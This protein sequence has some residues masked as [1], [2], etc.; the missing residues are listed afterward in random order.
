[1]L[2]LQTTRRK[3]Y[4]ILLKN[5]ITDKRNEYS[6]L[7]NQEDGYT[8]NEYFQ[9]SQTLGRIFRRWR[10]YPDA[11][12]ES[13][14]NRRTIGYVVRAVDGEFKDIR[15]EIQ[16]Y[17]VKC[18]GHQNSTT[19]HMHVMAGKIVIYYVTDY[20]LG[21][22]APEFATVEAKKRLRFDGSTDIQVLK[23]LTIPHVS[24]L[25]NSE[26]IKVGCP[27]VL[28]HKSDFIKAFDTIVPGKRMFSDDGQPMREFLAFC[29]QPNNPI[30][31]IKGEQYLNGKYTIP[32]ID[33]LIRDSEKIVI[34]SFNIPC[35]FD[36]IGAFAVNDVIT[37]HNIDVLNLLWAFTMIS[38]SGSVNLPTAHN[39]SNNQ[40]IEIKIKR[41]FNRYASRSLTAGA[42][43]MDR[44]FINEKMS[45]IAIIGPKGSGK[46]TFKTRLLSELTARAQ[47]Y[48]IIDSDDYGRFIT[49]VINNNNNSP[50][51]FDE[52]RAYKSYFEVLTEQSIQKKFGSICR[53][54]EMLLEGA[55]DSLY[56]ETMQSEYSDKIFENDDYGISRFLEFAQ[57]KDQ[58]VI[59]FCH[60]SGFA[61]KLPGHFVQ[62]SI[63]PTNDPYAVNIN[64]DITKDLRWT[65]T[66]LYNFYTYINSDM[67]QF[68]TWYELGL[69][70][71]FC[72]MNELAND[73]VRKYMK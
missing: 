1:M 39:Y 58:S 14:R 46:T 49:Y 25:Y 63:R 13:L 37:K 19:I 22:L 52:I 33:V 73:I 10:H 62:F 43:M 8:E 40:D 16:P 72:R 44:T 26:V 56:M 61:N 47:S 5:N 7:Y 55:S 20:Q 67:R 32:V 66:L 28:K 51:S 38:F 11:I 42:Q 48:T 30:N 53:N 65:N 9:F 68:L 4:T 60:D 12:I 6:H 15:P 29:A 3:F 45:S 21:F 18:S 34:G 70:L 2:S 36:L 23:N 54:D 69:L 27:V 31:D 24:L 35:P 71:D 59:L 64:R 50:T 41:V 57:V 17:V